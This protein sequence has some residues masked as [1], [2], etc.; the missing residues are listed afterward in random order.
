VGTV[1]GAAVAAVAAVGL[2]AAGAVGSATFEEL[3]PP[4]PANTAITT[5]PAQVVFLIF[6]LHL[7]ARFSTDLS[8]R[9]RAEAL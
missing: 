1:V 5:Q 6:C 9:D 4:H 7:V 3:P 8:L 2:D